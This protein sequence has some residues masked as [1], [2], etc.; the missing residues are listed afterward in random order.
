MRTLAP[1]IAAVVATAG[2]ASADIIGNTRIILFT[3]TLTG[4]SASSA[5]FIESETP[6][7]QNGVGQ[8][9]SGNRAYI[10]PDD[11]ALLATALAASTSGRPVA[12]Y[13][14]PNS[15]QVFVA[16]HNGNMTCKVT[17]L[18]FTNFQ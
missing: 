4:T 12:F 9:C 1:L 3:Q 16:G 5:H 15:E 13:Y 14:V 18:W 11:K 8:A 7:N 17:S 10:R 6:L 2:F